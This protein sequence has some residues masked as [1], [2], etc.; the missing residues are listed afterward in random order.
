MVGDG[1]NDAPALALA[2]VGIAMGQGTA[3]AKEVAD[4]TLTGGQLGSIVALR[5][6][7]EGLMGRLNGSFKEVMVINSTLL[8]AGIGGIISP[9]MSSLL[10]N[11][12]NVALSMRNGKRYDA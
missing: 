2:D 11:A 1:V 6:M 4:I 5:R 12:S 8:A 10:H 3:V 7:S 9:Q